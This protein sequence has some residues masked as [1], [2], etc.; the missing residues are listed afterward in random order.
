ME[1]V[2]AGEH[3]R[4]WEVRGLGVV[5]LC[6]GGGGGVRVSEG[7]RAN[8]R[9]HPTALRAC[10]AAVQRAV[11]EVVAEVLS[12]IRAAAYAR[13]LGPLRKHYAE[14]EKGGR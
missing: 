7:E 4:W 11:V 10:R 5:G 12:R 3:R 6:V 14:W 2:G 9:I 1:G 13:P 8:Q